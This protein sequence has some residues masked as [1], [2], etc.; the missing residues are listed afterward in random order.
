M[1]QAAAE[2][3]KSGHL[4]QVRSKN[5]SREAEHPLWRQFP[6]P[7][8]HAPF[9]SE[10]ETPPAAA[11]GYLDIR[12]HSLD[13]ANTSLLRWRSH[14][15]LLLNLALDEVEVQTM[16]DLADACPCVGAVGS[17]KETFANIKR[18][19]PQR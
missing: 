10:V 17:K 14:T 16:Q 12:S 13:R 5:I 19:S 2:G 7:H 18:N 1:N 4:R 11:A 6:W 9:W 15:H 3:Q 8:L